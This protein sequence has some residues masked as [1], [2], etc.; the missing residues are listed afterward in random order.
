MPGLIECASNRLS[1]RPL[2]NKQGQ[3]APRFDA[4]HHPLLQL[5]AGH[6]PG[7]K[8]P[9]Q[10]VGGYGRIMADLVCQPECLRERKMTTV[11][12]R[13]RRGGFVVLAARASTRERLLP[14]AVIRVPAFPANKTLAPL[15]RCDV[16]ETKLLAHRKLLNL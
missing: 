6:L 14:F 8:L 3:F 13:V 7:F 9:G 10:L 15:L 5:P 2:E 11:K 1:V 16:F 4:L 12:D